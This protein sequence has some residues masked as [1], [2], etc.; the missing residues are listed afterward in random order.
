MSAPLVHQGVMFLH[1]FPDTVLAIDATN[2]NVL[3]RYQYR[4]A[5]RS[6]SKMGIGLHNDKIYVPTSDNHV[7]AL[8][9]KPAN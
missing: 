9:A 7:L 4:Q 5:D 2:G 6:S 3:W 8:N 1:T